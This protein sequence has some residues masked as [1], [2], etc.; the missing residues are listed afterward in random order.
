MPLCLTAKPRTGATVPSGQARKKDNFLT[1][2]TIIAFI[3]IMIIAESSTF[4]V[5]DMPESEIETI[6]ACPPGEDLA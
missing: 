3:L 2:M 5:N 6:R 4:L 1:H